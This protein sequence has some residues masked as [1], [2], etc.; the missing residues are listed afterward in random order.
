MYPD[1]GHDLPV[2]RWAEVVDEIALN[3]ARAQSPAGVG[4]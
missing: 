3:A 2:H 1:M 4:S